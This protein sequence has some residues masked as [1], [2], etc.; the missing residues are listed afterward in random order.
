MRPWLGTW[1]V[2]A[3][4]DVACIIYRLYF[5]HP[6]PFGAVLLNVAMAA[7]IFVQVMSILGAM[8]WDKITRNSS[9]SFLAPA[10]CGALVTVVLAALLALPVSGPGA[11]QFPY[12]LMLWRLPAVL[13]GVPL[14][15]LS[16]CKRALATKHRFAI[17]Y[18]DGQPLVT[19]DQ[20]A[21]YDW[22]THVLRLRQGVEPALRVD[23]RGTPVWVVADGALCYTGVLGTI[24]SPYPQPGVVILAN[25]THDSL[26]IDFGYPDSSVA[27][28]SDPR[29]DSRVHEALRAIHV[30]DEN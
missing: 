19:A 18:T 2:A 29:A 12:W 4:T 26:A 14:L 1:L 8:C 21:A 16:F 27:K 24:L 25:I 11:G 10:A 6:D 23:V 28:G 13:S 5:L 9:V 7:M 20:V 30:L 15:Y 22:R 17:L 3:A